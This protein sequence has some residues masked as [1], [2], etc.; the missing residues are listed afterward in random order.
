MDK[1][2]SFIII[3]FV[4]MVYLLWVLSITQQTRAN[5]ALTVRKA[6]P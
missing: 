6:P 5:W 3:N 1:L 4:H 2:L